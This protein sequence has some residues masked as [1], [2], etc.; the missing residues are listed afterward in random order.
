MHVALMG[1][2]FNPPHIGHLL[3]AYF[4]HDDEG[5]RLKGHARRPMYTWMATWAVALRKPSDLGYDDTGYDL[6]GLRVI[7]HLIDVP[8]EVPDQLFA[9]DLGGVG[10]R[11]KVRS[12]TLVARCEQARDLVLA[13]PDEPWL[14]WCG[15]NAEATLI[16]DL[17]GA[18]NV[19]GG[20]TPE[21]KAEI[22]L[23]FA[24]GQIPRLVTKPSLAA[25]GLNWQHCARM[26]FVGLSDSYEAYYQA[27]RRCYRYGQHRVVDA[28]VIL[29]ELEGQI[30][31]N[32]ARKERESSAIT[33]GLV[34][35][36]R[37]A[38]AITEG[39]NA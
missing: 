13:E 28:H 25:F 12:E 32:I 17:T 30:A 26:A 36:M 7:P 14:F 1:G 27:I 6:P 5:W 19:H 3:A 22:L 4:V 33:S 29:S 15:L 18:V 10:G 23:A 21:E 37:I 38:R 34:E 9:T 39:A 16:A 31:T 11:A 2:S 24:D 8:I 35:Q 20:M